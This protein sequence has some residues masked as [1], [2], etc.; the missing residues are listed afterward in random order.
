MSQDTGAEPI[1]SLPK[2]AREQ[3][4]I[5]LTIAGDQEALRR[6]SKRT[7]TELKA[8]RAKARKLGLTPRVVKGCR[9]AGTQPKLRN[10]LRCS[11]RFLSV[12]RHNRMCRSCA[13]RT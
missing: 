6:F 5:D 13:R 8:V 3:R 10:C 12:G 4:I 11:D 9:L 1:Q 7:G 2:A